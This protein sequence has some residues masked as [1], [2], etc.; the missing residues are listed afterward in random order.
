MRIPRRLLPAACLAFA[1]LAPPPGATQAGPLPKVTVAADASGFRAADGRP[2]VPFGI[3]YYRPGQGWAPQ[4]WKQFDAAATRKDFATARALGANCVRVFLTFGSFYETPGALNEDGLRK[5]DTFLA[6][7]EEAGIYVHPTG[8]DHWEGLPEWAR[9]D[10]Y[11]DETFLAALEQ[12]WSAFATRYKG[13]AAI[14]AYDLLNEP[15]V[16]WNT[17]ALQTK[18]RAWLKQKYP[19]DEALRSA[20]K[21][22]D[23]AVSLATAP[24]PEPAPKPRDP[25]LLDYQHFREEIA[26]AWTRR[27][28]AAIRAADPAALV[29]VGLIQHAVPTDIL[30]KDAPRHYAAFRPSRIAPLLDFM[31]VHYYPLAEG[32]AYA[33]G[34]PGEERR[35]LAHAERVVREVALPGKPVV[36]AEF[37]WYGGGQL[38]NREGK[39]FLTP[40]TEEQQARYCRALVETTRGIAH[41]WLNWGFFDQPEAKDCSQLTGLLTADGKTKAWGHAFAAL[42]A[43]LQRAAPFPRRIPLRPD[44]DWDLAL[45]APRELAPYR[46]EYLKAFEHR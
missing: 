35:H 31:E 13:R 2:Y 37:G 28:A 21:T 20:W 36:V 10:R 23:A 24:V 40:S 29:T 44:L 39:P 46:A 41:G 1:A 45:T 26:V 30:A 8:P 34:G 5:F 16:P 3:N 15:A 43:E 25:A 18:W 17:A 7:A 27:Q 22:A 32:K 33:Y 42:A 9:A 38:T 11:A 14:F 6:L 4:V 19:G 12:F